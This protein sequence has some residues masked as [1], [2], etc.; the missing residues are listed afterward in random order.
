MPDLSHRRKA[1]NA[2]RALRAKAKAERQQ[3]IDDDEIPF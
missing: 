2:D 3:A 1:K